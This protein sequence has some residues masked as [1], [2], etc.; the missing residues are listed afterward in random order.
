MNPLELA[1]SQQLHRIA[2]LAAQVL[3]T[4]RKPQRGRYESERH[5]KGLL[6]EDKYSATST[7][8][9]PMRPIAQTSRNPPPDSGPHP[10]M[11]RL[12]RDTH[13]PQ[14]G[15]EPPS[16]S[17]PGNRQGVVDH[18]HDRVVERGLACGW[19]DSSLLGHAPAGG[20]RILDRSRSLSPRGLVEGTLFG[21][22]PLE[23]ADFDISACFI[24]ETGCA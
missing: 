4:L 20:P 22:M 17:R 12:T 9:R 15:T 11:H 3:I 7:D 6:D 8:P 13:P 5:L 19:K 24:A 18:S 23:P 2:A 16:S 10:A 14:P 21:L 1:E